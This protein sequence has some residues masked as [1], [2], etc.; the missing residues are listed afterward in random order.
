MGVIGEREAD[1]LLDLRE[2][3][4]A[5]ADAIDDRAAELL[6]QLPADVLAACADCTHINDLAAAL[7]RV[8]AE[9]E[10]GRA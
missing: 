10:A 7:V 3:A 1:A 5:A 6:D 8:V 9:R 2:R 4:E